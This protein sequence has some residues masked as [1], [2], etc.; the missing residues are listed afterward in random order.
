[1]AVFPM[2][3]TEKSCLH[4][5]QTINETLQ[6]KGKLFCCFRGIRDTKIEKSSGIQ[7]KSSVKQALAALHQSFPRA[8]MM[9]CRR[10]VE[11]P[12]DVFPAKQ[13]AT[14]LRLTCRN[15]VTSSF[16]APMKLVPLSENMRDG[17]PLRAM[18]RSIPMT[19]FNVSSASGQTG[20]EK[21]PSFHGRSADDNVQWSKI[22]YTGVCKRRFSGTETLFE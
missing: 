13:S 17:S 2:G 21:S 5:N 15:C 8:T 12:A 3:T 14:T 4:T 18:K 11:F 22:I 7:D 10:W 16:S 9:R 6:C 1:M 20:K 19:H